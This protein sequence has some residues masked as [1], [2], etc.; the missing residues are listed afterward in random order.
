MSLPLFSAF[1]LT[2]N[3][4]WNCDF[5]QIFRLPADLPVNLS[6]FIP[7]LFGFVLFLSGEPSDSFGCASPSGS[8][9]THRAKRTAQVR[10]DLVQER[11]QFE[12]QFANIPNFDQFLRVLE[13]GRAKTPTNGAED[14]R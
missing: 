9:E 8:S 10:L 1:I 2:S 3:R 5:E 11:N 12:N 7:M 13:G 6:M 4:S 14:R